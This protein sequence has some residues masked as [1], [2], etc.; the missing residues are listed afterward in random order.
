MKLISRKAAVIGAWVGATVLGAGALTG[1]A[2]AATSTTQTPAAGTTAS[3][4]AA[5]A[6][7][8]GRLGAA[9]ARH[10]LHGEFT[11]Q[12]K[13]GVRVLDTELGM[14]TSV[15]ATSV[16]AK[17]SDGYTQTWALGSTTRVRADGSKGSVSDLKVG[18]TV[19]LLGPAV[20]GSATVALAVVT[21]AA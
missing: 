1:V 3:A 14:I 7:R 18:Q 16:T 20:D 4:G 2:M 19:R 15:T 17:A 13:K 9:L 8:T 12:T 5:A 21:A 6:A 10:V 11:V